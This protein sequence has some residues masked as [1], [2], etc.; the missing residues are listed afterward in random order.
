MKR[1][2]GVCIG[3]ATA[4][5]ALGFFGVNNW[6][7]ATISVALGCFWLVGLYRD[8]AGTAT[9]GLLGFAGMA[10]LSARSAV[11]V[12][13]LLAS[14]IVALVAWDLQRFLRRLSASGQVLDQPALTRAHLRWSLG[15]AAAGL[16]IGLVAPAIVVP[17]PFGATLLLSALLIFGVSRAIGWLNRRA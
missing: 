10:A 7:G 8:W 3:V 6:F 14:V 5:L 12:P 17:L 13:I 16:L 1:L 2:I 4:L 15:V 11:A 9:L